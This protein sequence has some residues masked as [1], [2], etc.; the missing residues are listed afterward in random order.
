MSNSVS[1][2]KQRLVAVAGIP[3][4]GKSTVAALIVDRIGA[5]HLRTDEIRKELF[6]EPAYT[7]TETNTVYQTIHDRADTCLAGGGS[8]VL[9]AT[10]AVEADR[11]AVHNL[12]ADHGVGFQMVKVT[13]DPSVVTDRI[14]ERD[15]I[16]DADLAVSHEFRSRLSRSS[17]P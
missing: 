5:D 10:F 14:G 12:A 13:C 7:D 16:S 4:A 9:D 2:E 6:D 8:V 15:G 11:H 1:T 3:G 17:S